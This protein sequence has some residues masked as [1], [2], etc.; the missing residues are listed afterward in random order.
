MSDT[1]SPAIAPA[2]LERVLT[3]PLVAFL[4]AVLLVVGYGLVTGNPRP[5]LAGAVSLL[6]DGDLDGEERLRML[7]RVRALAAAVDTDFAHWAG[8]LA[9]IELADRAGHSAA[10]AALGGEPC[11]RLPALAE[12]RFLHQGNPMLANVFA[13]AV[14]EGA[15]DLVEA[16]AKWQQ[17]AVQ[18]R[19]TA[20]PWPGELA[21]A[22]LARL[23]K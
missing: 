10:V 8:L 3:C 12:R 13:A 18:A 21:A 9:C 2:S 20:K 14:A 17:V 11:R 19:L 22:A 23:Q 6:G 1:N 15:G 7:E 5:D 4:A 16:R